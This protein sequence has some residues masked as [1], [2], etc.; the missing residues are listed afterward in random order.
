VPSAAPGSRAARSLAV[1]GV[2]LVLAILSTWPWAAHLK[3]AVPDV[4]DTYEAAW[5]LSWGFH[6][7]FHDPLHLFDGNVFYPHRDT[8][9]FSETLYGIS[10]PLFPLLA[11]GV[12]PLAAYGIAVILGFAL[13]GFAAYRLARTLGAPAAGCVASPAS[14]SRSPRTVSGSSITSDRSGRSG[15]R[16]PSRRSCCSS[17][18]GPRGALRGSP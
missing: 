16:S 13:C 12:T 10:V 5:R 8:L 2:F 11:A 15:C 6:Q 3:N 17:G 14:P 18:R 4:V 7:T 1:F 9:A